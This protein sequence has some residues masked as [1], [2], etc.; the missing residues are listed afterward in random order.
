M[1]TIEE[2]N[3][4]KSG[5]CGLC[6]SDVYKYLANF[7]IL[8]IFCNIG[9]SDDYLHMCENTYCLNHFGVYDCDY[10]YILCG[11]HQGVLGEALQN[12]LSKLEVL[13]NLKSEDDVEDCKVKTDNYQSLRSRHASYISNKNVEGAMSIVKE[14]IQAKRDMDEANRVCAQNDRYLEDREKLKRAIKS[15]RGEYLNF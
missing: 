11:I 1:N 2:N 4:G 13:D 12:L 3:L 9:S 14:M 7:E 15:I 8:D 10:E 6:G 5:A